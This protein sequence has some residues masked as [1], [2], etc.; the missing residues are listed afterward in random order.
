MVRYPAL[1]LGTKT[2]TNVV[3]I[4]SGSQLSDHVYGLYN[5][6]DLPNA[7]D[8]EFRA[9]VLLRCAQ[10]DS[11]CAGEFG[12]VVA[13]DI[14]NGLIQ[15]LDLRSLSSGE[16]PVSVAVPLNSLQTLTEPSVV[17][18]GRRSELESN[19]SPEV[20]IVNPRLVLP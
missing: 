20:L 3:A 19:P 1:T 18:V 14:D 17:I 13:E 12:L 11:D 7:A 10:G 15:P 8:L 5:L 2:H 6:D 16:A 9:E 4:V